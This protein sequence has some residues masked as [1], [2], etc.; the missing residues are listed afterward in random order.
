MICTASTGTNH[1]DTNYANLNNIKIISLTKEIQTTKKISST[2]EHALAL[3]LSSIRNITEANKSV[4]NG[5]WDYT[6]FIGRQ[7]DHLTVGVIGYGRLG[8]KYSKYMKA[9]GAEVYF[10]DPYIKKNTHHQKITNFIKIISQSDIISLH[11]HINKET[12]HI[13][14]GVR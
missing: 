1:I 4:I 7:I 12:K 6:K 10:Y 13:I 11:I 8:R 2:A 14:Q 9:L 5:Y 3:T